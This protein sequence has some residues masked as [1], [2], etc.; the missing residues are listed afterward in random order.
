MQALIKA[1]A[2]L[3]E[4]VIDHTTIGDKPVEI[5][6]FATLKKLEKGELLCRQ[7]TH[8]RT[9]YVV[10]EGILTSYADLPDGTVHRLQKMSRGTFINDECLFVDLPVAYNVKVW[11][12]CGVL[13]FA[14]IFSFLFH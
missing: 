13:L 8:D 4:P 5:W 1:T 14:I 10:Q 6:K 11:I 9:L 3:L 12:R 2:E 7:Q